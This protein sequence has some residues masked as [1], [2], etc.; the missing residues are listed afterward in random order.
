MK[1]N[2]YFGLNGKMLIHIDED[3]L[4]SW[5]MKLQQSFIN[6]NVTFDYDLFKN[7]IFDGKID[8]QLEY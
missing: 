5:Y 6:Q 4:P 7:E 3:N 8:F 2:N 1:K